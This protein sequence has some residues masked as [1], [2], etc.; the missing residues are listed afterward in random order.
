M[1]HAV[2][3]RP[4]S[5]RE[6]GRLPSR[7]LLDVDQLDAREIMQVLDRARSYR[8]QSEPVKTSSLAGRT[9]ASLFYE[10][11]TRTLVSFQI[12]AQSLGAQVVN[13]AVASSSVV[14]GESLLDTVRT[15]DALGV[16]ALVVR[17][18]EAGAPYLAARYFSGCVINAGD[19]L[20]AHPTQALLDVLTLSDH[21]PDLSA[22]TVAIVGDVLHSR[23][24]RSTAIALLTLG[25]DVRFC[26][27]P[28]LLP[29]EG[30][31]NLLTADRPGNASQT[32]TLAEAL[33]DADVVM[34][35]RMQ[36]ERQMGGLLPDVKEYIRE[37]GLSAERLARLAPGA[38]WMHPGPVNEGVELD[39]DVITAP[40]SLISEQVANGV[41]IRM[42]VLDMLLGGRVE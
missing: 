22:I 7:H 33:E 4:S 13:V 28:T 14:K 3:H 32:S 35:L 17:H 31:L 15:F 29:E 19:G 24:A 25:A 16:D 1:N 12:A 40:F 5:G 37:Y 9:V 23:V 34:A 21:F 39:P 10:P 30:W 41:L 42:A 20:H 26:A 18:A 8:G 2:R 11:S 38:L 6:Q 27:P 36:R